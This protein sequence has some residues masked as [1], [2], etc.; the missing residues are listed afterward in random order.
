MTWLTPPK[1]HVKGGTRLTVYGSGFRPSPHL[2]VRFAVENEIEEV[3]GTY[4]SQS[5]IHCTTPARSTV[6]TAQ[7][8]VANDGLS[9]SAYPL[10]YVKGSGTFLKFVFDNSNPG[11]LDCMNTNLACADG[12]GN[13]G[14]GCLN[15]Y[16][17][18][19]IWDVDNSTGPYI[20]G[21]EVTIS[22]VGLNFP[23]A[24][25][26]MF[27][28]GSPITY[29]HP[30]GGP[31][32]PHP[33]NVNP[34]SLGNGPPIT[35]TFYPSRQLKCM[36]ECYID[37]DQDG[38]PETLWRSEKLD[39][40]WLD[41]TKVKCTSPAVPVPGRQNEDIGSTT[42]TIQV[43]ND[44]VTFDTFGTT[45]VSQS[46]CPGACGTTSAVCEPGPGS[47]GG[48]FAVF[49][50]Q[51]KVPHVYNIKS[52]QTS[53]WPARG[54]FQGNTE[55]TVTGTNFLPSR[56]LKCK[57][58]G[59]TNGTY[60]QTDMSHIVGEEGGRARYISSTEVICVTPTYGPASQKEQFK[61]CYQ[62]TG[63]R[64]IC[65][66]S[67]V[68]GS[69]A[70]LQVAAFSGEGIGTITVLRAGYG[71]ATPPRVSFLGAGG[72][73]A[74]ATPVLNEA[75]EITSVTIDK[76]GLN[77]GKGSGAT[78]TAVLSN[79]GTCTAVGHCVVASVTITAQGTGY[80]A[81]PEVSFV[82][83]SGGST[84]FKKAVGGQRCDHD[85]SSNPPDLSGHCRTDAEGVPGLHARAVAVLGVVDPDC[86]RTAKTC[87]SQGSVVRIDIVFPGKYYAT[88]P[89]VVLTP[90]KPRLLVTANELSERNR[91]HPSQV[92]HYAYQGKGANEYD[93][94]LFAAAGTRPDELP[95]S[96]Q[97]PGGLSGAALG[98]ERYPL[99][100]GSPEGRGP[101]LPPLGEAFMDGTI[102]PGHQA[103]VRVSNNYHKFGADRGS[104]QGGA[105]THTGFRDK[106]QNP[107]TGYWIW[108]QEGLTKPE[109]DKCRV[110]NN[111]PVHQ[112]A[113]LQGHGLDAQLGLG[114]VND[115]QDALGFH[116]TFSYLDGTSV[117]GAPGFNASAYAVLEDNATTVAGTAGGAF[118]T[119]ANCCSLKEIV[120]TEGGR[121]YND[122]PTVT[123][124]GGG[125]HGA[126]A[127]A[128]LSG[129]TLIRIELDPYSK[130]IDYASPP[131][132][133]I[134][135]V[136]QPLT[137]DASINGANDT[138]DLGDFGHN[139]YHL[140]ETAL[141]VNAGK[142]ANPSNYDVG[143]AAFPGHP[144]NANLGHPKKD[145]IHFL[146]SDIY[147]SP[148]GSDATGQ[149]TAARPYRT[150]QKCVDAAL[151]DPHAFYVYK[152]LDGGDPD[153]ALP[154]GT[155]RLGTESAGQRVD[156]RD[157][158]YTGKDPTDRGQFGEWKG[159][160][161]GARYGAAAGVP[162]PDFPAGNN[163]GNKGTGRS[164]GYTGRLVRNKAGRITGW[165][166]GQ[167]KVAKAGRMRWEDNTR[168]TQKGF[169]YLINRD[170]CVLKDGVYAG[171]GNKELQ[172]RGKMVQVW[173]EHDARAVID[174]KAGS[175]GAV[176]F[177]E[178]RHNED[179]ARVGSITMQGVLTR[180]CHA[181]AQPRADHRPYYVGRPGYGPGAR[182]PNGA[183]CWP[184][185]TGCQYR[186]AA[187]GLPAGF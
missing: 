114:T 24:P 102:K 22:A 21:T 10:V 83:P 27:V 109:I 71:Y 85:T 69:G 50:Y 43:S 169:G 128:V 174:C 117:R 89:T 66:P 144:G 176:A 95:G 6:H 132:V 61:H 48:T 29:T 108:S 19:E 8:T 99:G 93:P 88:A 168:D 3:Y 165:A 180:N 36:F 136:N 142:Y 185:S 76:A 91:N 49:R 171:P 54:P 92:G 62:T 153:P 47:C 80:L 131:A 151:Q 79:S 179:A 25:Y 46:Q 39:A 5:E 100:V 154:D 173:A 55:V 38:T 122:P 97:F 58:G 103:L 162:G 181:R 63:G 166:G 104:N 177:R 112:W 68:P 148:S 118:G 84:C 116:A 31:G 138:A 167:V 37:V 175:L 86:H 110:S 161:A 119:G 26:D 129:G 77:Y 30:V 106:T 32:T 28:K 135:P 186:R 14:N 101:L 96:A 145:C 42:C 81:P 137:Y 4:V 152:R 182:H 34:N 57:F 149:G 12:E 126:K 87:T 23:N 159:Q 94:A 11:C 17:V 183:F 111:P 56:Y 33:F 163:G 178:D 18:N 164:A 73:C 44:G 146:Y 107:P 35:G 187:D 90:A 120:V 9:F 82:C 140:D 1:G 16:Y 65:Y 155:A 45:K 105:T 134:T 40:E 121:G 172:P 7:V 113:A 70:V 147:V 98:Q 133:H 170:R 52:S 75:G 13:G 59:Y 15:P 41:Y 53:V 160:T 67:K 64:D 157:R 20:G 123:F 125:G 130:G 74:Q 141:S 2:K 115:E 124:S 158:A 150:I 156:A 143:H 184:G 51:D 60:E 139:T 78:A 127:K 72:C